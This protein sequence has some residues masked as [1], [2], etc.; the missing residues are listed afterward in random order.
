MPAIFKGDSNK[1]FRA[2]N[3]KIESISNQNEKAADDASEQA[4]AVYENSRNGVIAVILLIVV[5]AIALAV[6]FARW[7]AGHLEHA[8]S[9]A[10]SVSKGDLTRHIEVRSTDEIGRFAERNFHHE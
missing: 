5:A 3:E 6:F 9:V 1:L 2:M 8:V 10:E 7:I 4:N